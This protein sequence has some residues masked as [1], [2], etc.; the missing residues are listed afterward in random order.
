MRLSP[1]TIAETKRVKDSLSDSAIAPVAAAIGDTAVP[2]FGSH[3]FTGCRRL[4]AK[5][6]FTGAI[7][8][9]GTRS[10]IKPL[11]L[12]CYRSNLDS[13]Y[14]SDVRIPNM[15]PVVTGNLRWCRIIV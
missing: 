2:C 1:I 13:L 8:M 10:L 7:K 5:F 6:C 12:L 15:V 9:H 3:D 4:W 14:R 11:F